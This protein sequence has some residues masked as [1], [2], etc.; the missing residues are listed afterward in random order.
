MRCN[1]ELYDIYNEMNAI[2]GIKIRCLSWAADGW[3][4]NNEEDIRE[5]IE[6]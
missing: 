4:M 3:E 2:Y 6:R 5:L 1:K